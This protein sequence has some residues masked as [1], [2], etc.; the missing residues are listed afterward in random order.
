MA[1]QNDLT[2]EDMGLIDA[3]AS[4]QMGVAPQSPQPDPAAPEAQPNQET[5]KTPQESATEALPPT[6][7][8]SK[9]AQE[10]FEFFTVDMGDGRSQTYTPDQL[11]GIA[12][13]YSDLNYRH[14]TEVAPIKKSIGVLSQ[15]RDAAKQEGVDIDDDKLSELLLQSLKA[16]SHNPTMGGDHDE[17]DDGT[18]PNRQDVSI[19][20]RQNNVQDPTNLENMLS[21][22]ESDN[23]V[24]L[25]PMYKDA[26]SRTGNLEQKIGE[27]T[28]L[29]QQLA[30]AGASTATAAEGQLAD[31]KNLRA[32]AGK[33]QLVNNL[34]FIQQKYQFPDEAE[35]DFMNFVQGRGYDVMELLDRDLAEKLAS[36][37]KAVQQGP[38]LDR[39]RQMAQRRQAFTGNTAPSAGGGDTNTATPPAPSQDDQFIG[40]M[41]DEIMKQRNM[42]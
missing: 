12:T 15:I 39:F 14:Q 16:M 20:T 34:Q 2:P 19:N 30:Q 4:Q 24:T 32:E 8:G 25:P 37:F 5:P 28:E 38:E 10:P 7:E 11:R 1:D 13:R 23:A 21:Q 31:A 22:W 9:P 42:A 35:N 18:D 36:D 41:T 33:Q 3:V 17:G 40:E 26:I 29:V 6:V 27:L